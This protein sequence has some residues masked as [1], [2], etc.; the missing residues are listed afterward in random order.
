M[1][2]SESNLAP[3][4]VNQAL[5]SH[6]QLEA[7]QNTSKNDVAIDVDHDHGTPTASNRL[8]NNTGINSTQQ[9]T[10]MGE[11]L[12]RSVK[13]ELLNGDTEVSPSL[14]AMHDAREDESPPF[15]EL[16][17]NFPFNPSPITQPSIQDF[18]EKLT[19]ARTKSWFM[20]SRGESI[21]ASLCR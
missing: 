11:F 6:Q 9:N 19:L 10:A 4:G 1:N 16:R 8:G 13:V 20:A 15:S 12:S 21:E 3:G 17:P 2:L 18:A 7:S 14:A 5:L